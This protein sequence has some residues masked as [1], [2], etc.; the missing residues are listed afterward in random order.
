[1]C[2]C[3]YTE[4]QDDHPKS[5]ENDCWEKMPDDS[6]YTLAIKNFI[7]LFYF[8]PFPRKKRF[9][10][11][12]QKWRETDLWQKLVDDS[13]DTLGSKISLKSLYLAPFLR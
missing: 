9:Y 5:R 7:E 2:F 6:V 12:I 1:M 8:A 4:F 13:V 10:A 11:E 3:V